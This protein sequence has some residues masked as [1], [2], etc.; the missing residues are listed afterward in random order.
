MTTLPAVRDLAADADL[1]RLLGT[2]PAIAGLRRRI[3]QVAA[4]PLPVL[5]SGD[6]GTGKEA[7]ARTLHELSGRAGPFVAV[8]CAALSPTLVETEL[9]GHERG[10][11]TGAHQRREGL[12]GSARGGTFFLDEIGELSPETQTRLLRLLEEGTYRPV[13]DAEERR[14]DI[15][16]VAA[17]WRDLRHRVAE[18]SFRADLYHRLSIVVLE[19][20]PL[21]DRVEDIDALFE[22]FLV[23]AAAANARPVPQLSAAVRVHLRRWP[24][25]GNVRELRN[26]ASFV[27]AMTP[28]AEVQM[29]DLPPALLRPPPEVPE[30]G[31]YVFPASEIRIDLPY[32]DARRAFL[33]DF[34]QRYVEAIL[35]ANGG[36]VSAAARAAGMDRRSIQRIVGRSRAPRVLR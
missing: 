31:R 6:T 28:R 3:R 34:Q 32:M 33:D 15:R 13:G 20:P 36:N 11:F 27:A 21:R 5:L 2:S 23:E 18:G 17:T 14:A 22:V 12:V 7:A 4:T 9:F 1:P 25:P 19:L 35:A 29:A 8:D 26:V 10:A 16:V 30:A 24:W